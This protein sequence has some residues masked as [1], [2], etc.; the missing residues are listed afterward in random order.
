[1]TLFGL[2]PITAWSFAKN[3]LGYFFLATAACPGHWS[4]LAAGP[5]F[6]RIQTL[7][8]CRGKVQR[9]VSV[10]RLAEQSGL[11]RTPGVEFNV[12][13]LEG[14]RHRLPVGLWAAAAVVADDV[15]K[16]SLVQTG[17]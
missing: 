12:L 9:F 15:A 2:L 17:K 11:G 13:E 14:S 8:K 3:S 5:P 10:V 1:M 7:H 16:S 6:T 4:Y